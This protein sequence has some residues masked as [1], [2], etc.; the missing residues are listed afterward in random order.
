MGKRETTEGV[1]LPNQENILTFGGNENY[2][3]L[4]ISKADT[5]KQPEI[6]ENNKK[7]L[8]QAYENLLETKFYSRNP[9]KAINKR[10]APPLHTL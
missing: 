9:I 8:L 3:N 6:S 5:T 4:G 1:E 7:S 2:K 10:A